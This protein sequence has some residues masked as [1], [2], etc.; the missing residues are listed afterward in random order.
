M[1]TAASGATTRKRKKAEDMV[2]S[3]P[4]RLTRTRTTKS[5]EETA[6]APKTTRITTASA[7]VAA[8]AR[9]ASAKP[10]IKPAT[11]AATT[12]RKTKTEDKADQIVPANEK[13]TEEI[14]KTRTRVKKPEKATDTSKPSTTRTRQNKLKVEEKPLVEESK[15]K[16]RARKSKIEEKKSEE[17]VAGDLQNKSTRRTTR[18]R[19]ETMNSE[20]DIPPTKPVVKKIVKKVTFSDEVAKEKE[21]VPLPQDKYKQSKENGIK[22]KPIRKTTTT[23]PNTRGRKTTATKESEEQPSNQPL[24]PK[25]V[26]QVAKSNSSA[27]SE[28]ELAK[29]PMKR[30]MKSPARNVILRPETPPRNTSASPVIKRTADSGSVIASPAKRPA[31]SPSKDNLKE[32]PRKFALPTAAPELSSVLPADNLFKDSL[33]LSPKKLGLTPHIQTNDSKSEEN[34]RAALLGSPARRPASPLKVGSMRMSGKSS[35]ALP[36]TNTTSALR[37]VKS[38]SLLSVTP[39]R[40]FDSPVKSNSLEA[41][42]KDYENIQTEDNEPKSA[43]EQTLQDAEELDSSKDPLLSETALE[44]PKGFDKYN[45]PVSFAEPQQTFEHDVFADSGQY[46]SLDDGAESEDELAAASP[47]KS[48][49]K[50]LSFSPRGVILSPASVASPTETPKSAF[51]VKATPKSKI[52]NQGMTPLAVQLSNWLASS[53]PKSDEEGHILHNVYT[54]VAEVL[55]KIKSGSYRPSLSPKPSFFEEQL[56][57]QATPTP[58]DPIVEQDLHENEDVDMTDVAD[59][60][61]SQSTE[62]GDENIIPEVEMPLVQQQQQQ[63]TVTPA[64]LINNTQKEIHTVARVPLKP[65]DESSSSIKME[66]IRSKSLSGPLSEIDISDEAFMQELTD[67]AKQRAE[68]NVQGSDDAAPSSRTRSRKS[69][70]TPRKE[71]ISLAGTP[72]KPVREGA[73]AQ[74][75]RGAVIH[76]DVHTIEGS[77]A[78]GVFID[79]LTHMGARC[80]K[81]WN[82]NSRTSMASGEDLTASKVGITHVVFKDGS[83]RTLQKVR[84]AKGLVLCVGVGWVLE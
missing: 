3:P 83:K 73:D 48:P 27:S 63:E 2:E 1:P 80:V 21:N 65:A 84:E 57:E 14:P 61:R 60:K 71:I 19:A 50:S 64:K 81:Q 22:A 24:S 5:T 25:K 40:L 67:L 17:E 6:T 69:L 82:W 8:E 52:K 39:K 70:G 45:E 59:L 72:F 79:L 62:Y 28:D 36:I 41:T 49:R 12:R 13:T 15:P 7:R 9:A 76:V 33:K 29:S 68:N 56:P 11:T 74:I 38:S 43:E 34:A 47:V 10:V 58:V 78:N 4:K 35:A 77:E 18:T 66:K 30:P 37:H 44:S 16:T 31:W 23:R 42:T 55:S 53:P 46:R 54:P 20:A 75:L 32:S 51:R 26:T